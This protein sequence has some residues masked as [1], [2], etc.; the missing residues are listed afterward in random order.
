VIIFP[1]LGVDSEAPSILDRDAN[2][3]SGLPALFLQQEK[4]E[5]VVEHVSAVS[6]H[7]SEARKF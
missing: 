3:S 2:T 1:S 6:T 4:P 7:A 5:L